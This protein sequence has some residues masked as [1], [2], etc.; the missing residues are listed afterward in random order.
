MM[1]VRHEAGEAELHILFALAVQASAGL[2]CSLKASHAGVVTA[3]IVP[4]KPRQL[5]RKPRLP[6]WRSSQRLKFIRL[7]ELAAC[8]LYVVFS[9]MRKLLVVARTH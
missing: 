1:L 9:T 4:C 8:T 5:Y 2:A 7:G 3:A 6:T